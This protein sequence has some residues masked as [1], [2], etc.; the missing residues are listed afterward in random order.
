[1]DYYE[2]WQAVSELPVNDDKFCSSCSKAEKFTDGNRVGY[3]CAQKSMYVNA[4]EYCE[5]WVAFSI[6]TEVKKEKP[7]QVKTAF[8]GQIEMI[9]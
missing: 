1:M 4:R 5:E 3:R 6:P 9:F 2:Y 7:E 8:S